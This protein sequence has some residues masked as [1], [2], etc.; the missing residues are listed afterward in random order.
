MRCATYALE[1]APT[2][3]AMTNLKLPSAGRTHR[4]AP[5]A[6][7]GFCPKVSPAQSI[8]PGLLYVFASESWRLLLVW[9]TLSSPGSKLDT[10]PL[11]AYTA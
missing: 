9:N 1:F 11:V 5:T 2:R 6:K 3:F 7:N 8:A 4:C 10:A